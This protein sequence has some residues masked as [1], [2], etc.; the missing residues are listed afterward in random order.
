[1]II[2]KLLI[3]RAIVIFLFVA[4][5]SWAQQNAKYSYSLGGEVFEGFILRHHAY[6]GHLIKGRPSGFEISLKQQTNGS[7]SW[8]SHYGFPE[9]AYN[10]SFYDL[11]NE[12]QLGK[13]L[14]LSAGM[15]FHLLGKPPFKSDLQFYF[16]MGLAYATNPYN[17]NYNNL[18]NVISS[19]IT[20]NGNLKLAYYHNIGSKVKIGLGVK[21]T[22]FSNGSFKLPNNGLNIVTANLMASY[23]FM[24]S[25]TEFKKEDRERIMDK[26]LKFGAVV[27][28]GF[29]ESPPIGTGAKPVYGLSLVAQKRVSLKSLLE[30]GLE[31]FAN[32]SIQSEIENSFDEEVIGTDYRRVG[33]I[34]GHQL[35]VNRLT[36]VSQIGVYLYKP[37][38]PKDRFYQRVG[39]NYNFTDN[40]FGSV[41]LKTH[42]AVAEVIEY[43]IGYRL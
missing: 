18:N 11:K 3:V 4:Q 17:H 39:F 33:F 1:M 29:A 41:T 21:L 30:I 10:F 9:I 40:L 2:Q 35:V 32:K 16:G 12:E 43:G 36:V 31:G 5:I 13:V 27:R 34:F 15:G 26:S 38:F 19:T 14:A 8:E 42:F 28:I 20:Y 37:Y 6:L 22:H 24:D 23:K 25:I 7:K